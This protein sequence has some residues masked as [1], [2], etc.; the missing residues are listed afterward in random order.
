MARFLKKVG[1]DDS[2]LSGMIAGFFGFEQ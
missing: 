1:R 2:D